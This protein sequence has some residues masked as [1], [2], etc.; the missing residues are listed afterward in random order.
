MRSRRMTVNEEYI[1]TIVESLLKWVDEE[2]SFTV[3]QYLAHRGIGYSYFKYLCEVSPKVHFAFEVVKS[4]LCNK[5]VD[6][7]FQDAQGKNLNQY[8]AKILLRYINLYDLHGRD[9]KDTERE[10][11]KEIEAIAEMKYTVESYAG[12]KL[13]GIHKQNYETNLN[14]R[15]S[16]EGS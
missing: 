14:K 6:F 2:G 4:K 10:A 5:W 15:R 12:T 11:L 16:E 13:D 9:V 7:A 3:P 1:D 8:Q